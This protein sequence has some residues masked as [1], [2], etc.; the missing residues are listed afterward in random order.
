MPLIMRDFILD[1]VGSN[2]GCKFSELYFKAIGFGYS[3]NDLIIE[4][5]RLIQE[6]ELVEVRYYLKDIHGEKIG[7]LFPKGTG[8]RITKPIF[9]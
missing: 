9:S 7:V 8:I 4:T 3:Y 2:G 5:N 6:E 1:F